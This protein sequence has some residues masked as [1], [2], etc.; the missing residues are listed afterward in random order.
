MK[1]N[2]IIISVLSIALIISLCFN[3][4]QNI[5]GKDERTDTITVTKVEY[6][7]KKYN[8]PSQSSEE[9]KGFVKVR[10]TK[11][12]DSDSEIMNVGNDQLLKISESGK[13]TFVAVPIT[14]KVYKDS[15]YTA[16]VSGYKQNLDSIWIR[17][18]IL[19]NT[20]TITK[21]KEKRFSIGFVGGLGYGF[22]SKKLEPFVGFGVSYKLI[23]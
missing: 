5:N 9:A 14:Q 15:L 13:D 21:V 19:T 16:F 12:F 23:K 3:Y 22:S 18:K 17:E 11:F 20:I 7:E 2:N 6:K 10:A 4:Y 1:T 8:Q